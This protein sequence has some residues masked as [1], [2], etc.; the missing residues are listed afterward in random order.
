MNRSPTLSWTRIFRRG[1]CW[2]RRS[3]IPSLSRISDG[4]SLGCSRH[5]HE[6]LRN[7]ATS[8]SFSASHLMPSE[9]ERICL[10]RVSR[11]T[12]RRAR[13]HRTSSHRHRASSRHVA[14]SRSTVAIRGCFVRN[15]KSYGIAHSEYSAIRSLFL[16]QD[17][18]FRKVSLRSFPFPAKA[19]CAS[20]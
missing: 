17:S 15:S 3:R 16:S 13:T 1:I 19:R 7:R 6:T 18:P 2:R 4:A 20:P 10:P 12:W 14:A 5:E 11:T 8:A 9:H